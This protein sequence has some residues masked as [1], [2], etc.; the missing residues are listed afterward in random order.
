MYLLL[1]YFYTCCVNSPNKQRYFLSISH[2]PEYRKNTNCTKAISV[3][4]IIS[5]VKSLLYVPPNHKTKMLLV[6]SCSS[7]CVI[8][9]IQVLSREW[10]CS[11]NSA[12]RR[13]SNYIWVMNNFI[14]SSGA[15]YIRNLT[16]NCL[17]HRNAILSVQ[18]VAS[19]SSGRRKSSWLVYSSFYLYD[20]SF[21][22]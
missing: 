16:V 2:I 12:D 13:C 18:Q 21:I 1:A 6:S 5:T 8:Y 19:H 15:T 3:A 14:D 9:W 10:R 4:V 11:W 20:I 22:F 7:L 17:I